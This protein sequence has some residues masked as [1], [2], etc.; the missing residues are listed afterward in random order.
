MIH[1]ALTFLITWTA[2]FI[3][4][5]QV[6]YIKNKKWLDDLKKSNKWN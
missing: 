3:S 6:D 5:M 1:I 4:G 2:W